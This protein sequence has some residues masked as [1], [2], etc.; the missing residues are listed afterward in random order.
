MNDSVKSIKNSRGLSKKTTGSKSGKMSP[1]ELLSSVMLHLDED[2]SKDMEADADA[3]LREIQWQLNS[4]KINTLIDAC[5]RSSLEVITRPLGL[6]RVLFN[7]TR[8]G[9]V[10]TTQ[11]L[12][13]N[14][15]IA[16]GKTAYVKS[17][18]S[19]EYVEKMNVW[20]KNKSEFSEH[21]KYKKE[22]KKW[23]ENGRVGD[24][25]QKSKK[26]SHLE[27]DPKDPKYIFRNGN[28]NYKQ[29]A[30]NKKKDQKSGELNNEF[31]SGTFSTDDKVQIDHLMS[32]EDI[33]TDRAG[34]LS[35]TDA[36]TL[37]N[38][39]ENLCFMFAY[40]NNKKSDLSV[41]DAIKQW[42]EE[43]PERLNDIQEL[44]ELQKKGQTTEDQD[45][46]LKKFIQLQEMDTNAL[47][48]VSK[49]A[50]EK[51]KSIVDKNHYTSSK[52]IGNTIH[53]SAKEGGKMALQQ[54]LGVL[55]EELVRALFAEVKDIWKNG[56]KG[57]VDDS[58][59][60]TL[61]IRFM[62]VAA[63]VQSR[64]KDAL[65]A[66]KDGFIS[67]LFSN[68][69][70]IFVNIFATTAARL[71]RMIREGVMSLYHAG[72]ALAFPEK[73]AS[74]A[75]AA[76]AALKILVS[77]LIAAGGIVIEATFSAY[78]APL[79]P[80]ADW[81]S[82][83]LIGLVTGVATVSIVYLLDEI[84]FFG[85]QEENRQNKIAARLADIIDISYE[86]GFEAAKAFDDIELPHLT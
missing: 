3:M 61:K 66:L 21:N 57:K 13:D 26:I 18:E 58:F 85:V 44:T 63:R 68:L 49:I 72:K 24:E 23:K 25:A 82:V 46:D 43:E 12:R 60:K 8:G 81:V 75:E 17:G 2:N 6:G 50:K 62:R 86:D 54:A 70:T 16:D 69:V 79:G 41:E 15:Y 80:L 73:G 37:A 36:S 48:K 20:G 74:L 59:L 11:N 28:S 78:L 10:T 52:F 67:G 14:E 29:K 55:M 27:K 64:W 9:N 84:D 33:A 38:I 22:V 35:G 65:Y 42:K 19:K 32:V 71:G 83:I 77:G 40:I 7:D 51:Q 56:F 4:E 34:V 45:N 30:I 1:E 76:D 53:T 31:G 47:L 5:Q 39:P